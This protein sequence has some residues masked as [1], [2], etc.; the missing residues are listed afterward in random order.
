MTVL[1]L[2]SRAIELLSQYCNPKYYSH[3]DDMLRALVNEVPREVMASLRTFLGN[4]IDDD[5]VSASHK[6]KKYFN[7][8]I[9]NEEKAEIFI[10]E[11]Y[12]MISEHLFAD[13]E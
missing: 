6:V 7:L 12:C 10:D 3:E 13:E 8:S 5:A 2:E 9:N 4:I 11:I 1:I